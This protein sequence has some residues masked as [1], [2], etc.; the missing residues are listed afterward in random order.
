MTAGWQGIR[1]YVSRPQYKRIERWPAP[2][3]ALAVVGLTRLKSLQLAW[4]SSQL[5]AAY[6]RAA[7]SSVSS[8]ACRAFRS[9]TT[10]ESQQPPACHGNPCLSRLAVRSWDTFF[11]GHLA[12][13]PQARHHH[14]HRRQLHP[15]QRAHARHGPRVQA[16]QR[17]QQPRKKETGGDKITAQHNWW[18]ARSVHAS[19]CPSWAENLGP[20]RPEFVQC[21]E[22]GS[23]ARTGGKHAGVAHNR[24]HQR[25]HTAAAADTLPCLCPA[26]CS[27][28]GRSW[29]CAPD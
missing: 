29:C 25:A 9:S 13:R 10:H 17:L 26:H 22:R 20:L 3:A 16:R 23:G 4:R 11:K 24:I 1:C 6:R 7:P 2:G 14:G 28:P 21:L 5:A 19:A 18:P 27:L 15:D 8:V 12:E